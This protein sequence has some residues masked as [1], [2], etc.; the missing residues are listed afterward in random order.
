M[1][2][3]FQILL[4]SV[5]SGVLSL[6]GG[7]ALLGKASWMKKF[8]LH[9]ISFAA[10]VLLATALLDLMPEALEESGDFSKLLAYM[11]IGIVAFFVLERI[12]LKFIPSHHEDIGHH[13]HPTP[14]LMQ[15]GDILHN[16]I[17]GVAL[18]I[19]FLVN[20]SLGMTTALAIAA[21][22]LPQ[23]ISDFS[24]MLNH[25]Y[26]KKTVL[27]VNLLASLSSVFGAV[28]AFALRDRIE[29]FLPELLAMTAGIFIYISLVDLIPEVTGHH[30]TDKAWHVIALMLLGIFSVGLLSYY[31]SV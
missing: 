8:S 21:H 17:D 27:V 12:I 6:I 5:L 20:P 13:H 29:P 25:G 9:F 2:L 19:S 10:G 16:F 1:N 28:L 14:I 23:E 3:F 26:K 11:L 15:I 7:I 30:N 24:V 22:E 4:F 18:T 31:L